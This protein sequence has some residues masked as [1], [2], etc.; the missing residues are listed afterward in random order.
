M[1]YYLILGINWDASAD[2]IKE[3]IKNI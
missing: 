1:D 2:E 3:I